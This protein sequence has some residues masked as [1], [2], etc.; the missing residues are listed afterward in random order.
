MIK[1]NLLLVSALLLCMATALPQMLVDKTKLRAWNGVREADTA[2]IERLIKARDAA[3][4]SRLK[5]DNIVT[6]K[7]K[8]RPMRVASTDPLLSP[9]NVIDDG[10]RINFNVVNWYLGDFLGIGNVRPVAGAGVEEVYGNSELAGIG[11]GV[12][13]GGKYYGLTY[14][15][16]FGQV[17]SAT[18]YAYDAETWEREASIELPAQWYSVYDY[19]AYN[20]KDGKIYVLGF[21]G[22]HL[23]YLSVLDTGTGTYTQLVQCNV[24][25]AAMALHHYF[26]GDFYVH[27]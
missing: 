11:N 9:D 8:G 7:G 27:Y 2:K 15:A 16:A 23:P 22:Y 17:L 25:I 4:E 13:A 1:R 14:S 26:F 5:F 18:F 21:D 19:A 10:T 12:Y 3:R 20:P 24:G 6:S